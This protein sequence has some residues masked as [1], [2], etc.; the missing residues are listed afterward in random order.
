MLLWLS[1]SFL[2]RFFLSVAI[3]HNAAYGVLAAPVAALLF[4]YVT[5]LA[6][7]LGAEL[8]AQLS[9]THPREGPVDPDDQA[10]QT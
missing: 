6:I 9:R 2:L 8:N 3:A 5:A 1:G 4:L 10:V 7:L